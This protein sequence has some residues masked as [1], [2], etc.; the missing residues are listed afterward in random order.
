VNENPRRSSI[1]S[2]RSPPEDET[3]NVHG[4]YFSGVEVLPHIW[5]L[6]DKWGVVAYHEIG[7]CDVNQCRRGDDGEIVRGGI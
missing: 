5:E 6:A 1:D 2:G 3:S 4:L 7:A